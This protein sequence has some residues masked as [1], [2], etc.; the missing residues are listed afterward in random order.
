MKHCG[1]CER[2]LPSSS[3]YRDA[4]RK[5]GLTTACK[6]CQRRRQREL[7]A[8]NADYR[9][10]KGGRAD[11]YT[12]RSERVL[13]DATEARERKNEKQRAKY[14]ARASADRFCRRCDCQLT[15]G[16][17]RTQRYCSTECRE[18]AALD[19]ERS[20]PRRPAPPLARL[21]RDCTRPLDSNRRWRCDDCRRENAREHARN[22]YATDPTYR[23]RV[24]DVAT[25]RYY[26]SKLNVDINALART[27]ETAE[28]QAS[29]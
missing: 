8:S 5:D 24:I 23:Q 10:K 2:D 7:Y 18:L 19:R 4:S 22:R 12:P 27:L 29:A 21:C 16:S 26:A 25:N 6:E 9:V 20:R 15:P 13:V 14:A 11:S 17:P 1:E 28:T 3:F